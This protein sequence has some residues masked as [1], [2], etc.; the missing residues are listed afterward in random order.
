MQLP[1]AQMDTPCRHRLLLVVS[2][3]PTTH[4]SRGRASNFAEGEGDVHAC[5]A[6][7]ALAQ[8]EEGRG[9]QR[10]LVQRR[11]LLPAGG[12]GRT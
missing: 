1:Q 5:L 3:I 4:L 9:S 7:V 6:L 12:A 10:P 8:L 11:R 2:C